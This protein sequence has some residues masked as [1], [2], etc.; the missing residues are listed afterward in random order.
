MTRNKHVSPP[1]SQNTPHPDAY[2]EA[3]HKRSN[4][5]HSIYGS[6]PG[7][8]QA[9]KSHAWTKSSLLG[10]FLF[11]ATSL[12]MLAFFFHLSHDNIS[13]QWEAEEHN[14]QVLRYTWTAERKA[15]VMKWEQWRKER[16]NHEEHWEEEEKRSLIVLDAILLL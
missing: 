6:L 9:K 15:M 1:P 11:I 8:W 16:V 13:S 5:P 3:H 4:R 14:H 7:P 12:S 10:F 2:T